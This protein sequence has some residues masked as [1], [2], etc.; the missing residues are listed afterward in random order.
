MKKYL[1]ITYGQPGWRGVQ[2]RALRIASYLPKEE[3]LFWNLYDSKFVSEYGFEVETKDAGLVD[4]E[5][6]VFPKGIE[7]VIFADLPSNEL[8][9]YSVFRAARARGF[10]IVICE[11]LYRRGQLQE[12]VYKQFVGQSDLF[13]VNS[14]SYF[15][16]EEKD[17]VKLVPPQVEIELDD[18]IGDEVRKRYNI[19]DNAFVIFGVGYHEEALK[20]IEELHYRLYQKFKQVYTIVVGAQV[21]KK[22][23][24]NKLLLPF[25]PG[26]EY[27]KLL[28]MADLAIVKFGFLQILEAVALRKPTI[29]LGE[30]GYLLKTPDI[31][32]LVFKKVLRFDL[33]VNYST[34]S[35]IERLIT[36][37]DFYKNKVIQ[38]QKLH[39]GDFFGARKAAEEIKK[40]KVKSFDKT[41]DKSEKLKIRSGSLHR[42]K[43]VILI[44]NEIFEK[45]EWLRKQK[46]IYPLCFIIATGTEPEVVKRVPSSVLQKKIEDLQVRHGKEILPHSFKEVF[47]FSNRKYDGFTDIGQWHG[48]LVEHLEKLLKE[49]DDIYLSKQGKKILGDLI[50]NRIKKKVKKLP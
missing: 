17:S 1:F 43:L 18:S 2:V 39:N 27:F 21:Q 47:V 26:D 3:V 9:E 46:N 20:K 4:P 32:D 23:N 45:E 7:V 14:V 12:W 44:N 36:N 10:K 50:R 37:K 25:Q 24:D 15:K 8:F 48:M 40:L 31:L 29:V 5:T 11:Q 28:H 6:I 13:L 42:K 16:S 19:P 35:Y 30:G 38:L 49:A 34:Y 33:Q 22:D 41:Q